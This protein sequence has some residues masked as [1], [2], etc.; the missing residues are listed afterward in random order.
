MKRVL[1]ILLGFILVMSTSLSLHSNNTSD[2]D[3]VN[4][5]AVTPAKAPDAHHQKNKTT[6][7]FNFE[8]EELIDII[9]RIAALKGVNIL[10]PTGANAITTKVTMSLEEPLDTEAAWDMLSTL[11]SMADYALVLHGNTYNIVKAGKNVTKEPL[12][13]YIG[14]SPEKLPDTD[15][16]INY[17]YYFSNLRVAADD[18]NEI[19]GIIK[20]LLPDAD[21]KVDTI[22]NGVLITEKSR[23]IKS[24]MEILLAIDQTMYREQLQI[25]TLRYT[26]STLV[27]KLFNENILIPTKEGFRYRLDNKQD[28]EPSY[29]AKQIKIIPSTRTNA[30]ILL[31]KTQAIERVIEFIQKY[32]DV[33]LDSGKSILHVYELQYLDAS[34]F[35]GVLRQ[36]VESMKGG[37][38]GQARAGEAYSATERYLEGVLIKAVKP[39]KEAEATA[40]GNKLLIAARNDDWKYIEQ[41]ISE[42]DTPMPQVIIEVLVA[43]L[44]L[45]DTRKLGNI[46]RNPQELSLPTGV[47]MQ[48]AHLDPGVIYPPTPT[49]LAEDLMIDQ[50]SIVG[51]NV[52]LKSAAGSTLL[53]IN[54]KDGKTWSVLQFLQLFTHTKILSHPHVVVS[55]NKKAFISIGEQRLLPD[56]A[57]AGSSG[58]T[59]VRY[60]PIE[61]SLNV[62][63]MPR[64]SFS[65]LKETEVAQSTVNLDIKID[66]VEFVAGSSN[67]RIT[68]NIVTT[69]NVKNGGILALGGLINTVDQTSQKSTPILSKIPILGWFFK[70][71]SSEISKT[72]LTVFI[73]P[74]IIIPQL[75]G[76]VGEYTHDYIQLAKQYSKEG[77]LFDTLRDPIT[78]WFFKSDTDIFKAAEKFVAQDELMTEYDYKAQPT[79]KAKNKSTSRRKKKLKELLTAK[80]DRPTTSPRF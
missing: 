22:T 24:A 39:E 47:N 60:K 63:I 13:I 51:N 16:P 58:V 66:V 4:A 21:Y 31:G 42:L 8:N 72:N 6:L 27:T 14:T 1:S 9:N 79:D 50:S 34:S 68:R 62:N 26:S 18:K 20:H 36:L 78:R 61:A 76:G 28:N 55:N 17:L 43:D 30:L 46:L 49:T 12:P 70:D 80:T 44:T 37:G 38:T 11:L 53:T 29:F 52:A 2:T 35:E 41:L 67:A 3:S 15:Q 5:P 45:D 7:L 65:A 73:S 48:A 19:V 57:S 64:I 77:Q 23:N 56:E 54:D 74:T 75:R 71:K 32:I 10:L 25:L 69:A 40:T 59:T 33:P